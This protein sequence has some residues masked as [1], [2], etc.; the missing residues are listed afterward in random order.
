[1]TAKK[2]L[3]SFRSFVFVSYKQVKVIIFMYLNEC[4]VYHNGIGGSVMEKWK[5]TTVLYHAS[6]HKIFFVKET[7]IG[8][9]SQRVKGHHFDEN[10]NKSFSGY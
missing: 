1:M 2:S 9:H 8:A 6:S 7:N 4:R 3:V 5:K 10:L